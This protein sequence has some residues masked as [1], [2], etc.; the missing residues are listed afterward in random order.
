MPAGSLLR[1]KVDAV[2]LLRPGPRDGHSTILAICLV[3]AVTEPTHI[4]K[5]GTW[6][7]PF[8]EGNVRGFEATLNLSQALSKKSVCTG[9]QHSGSVWIYIS[10][11]W[12]QA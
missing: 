5:M 6:S 1:E 2:S 8:D 7:L 9:S 3:K 4:Q 12:F 10:S 11:L